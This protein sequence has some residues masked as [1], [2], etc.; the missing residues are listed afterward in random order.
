MSNATKSSAMKPA[1]TIPTENKGK[2]PHT[3]SYPVGAEL[4]STALQD[5]PQIKTLSISFFH[6]N[7]AKPPAAKVTLHPVLEAHYS[8]SR[9]TFSSSNDMIER[10]WYLP[11]WQITVRPVPRELKHMIKELLLAEGFPRVR[12]WLLER[13]ALTEAEGF[14]RITLDFDDY[15]GVLR[16]EEYAGV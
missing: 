1:Y 8:Y 13:G 12:A 7:R 3:L 4:I 10:G 11:K 14:Q 5:V 6:Y 9:P 15:S 2:I 16:S